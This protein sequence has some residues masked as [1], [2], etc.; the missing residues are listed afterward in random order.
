M[1]GWEHSASHIS[2]ACG[3]VS[4]GLVVKVIS[5][6]KKESKSMEMG[7][8]GHRSGELNDDLESLV[9]WPSQRA[10]NGTYAT[11]YDSGKVSKA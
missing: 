6:L 2:Y 4:I 5:C 8:P 1:D 7:A 11:G 3:S 10:H 9:E